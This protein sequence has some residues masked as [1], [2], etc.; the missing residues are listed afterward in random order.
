M[1]E[2]LSEVLFI[3]C[4]KPFS[5]KPC[6][7]DMHTLVLW[8]QNTTQLKALREKGLD[9]SERREEKSWPKTKHSEN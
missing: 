2:A 9:E 1:F 4:L 3:W 8:K 6:E 7:V 5:Q